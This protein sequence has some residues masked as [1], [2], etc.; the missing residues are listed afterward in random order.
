MPVTTPY[1]PNLPRKPRTGRGQDPNDPQGAAMRLFQSGIQM[2]ENGQAR[3]S[4][5]FGG[6]LAKGSAG[7]NSLTPGV[8]GG[9]FS[10]LGK[11]MN[12][13]YEQNPGFFSRGPQG[14]SRSTVSA[15]MADTSF[16]SQVAE[17]NQSLMGSGGLP[18]DTP[19]AASAAARNLMMTGTGASRPTFPASAST[20]GGRTRADNIAQ[21]KKDGT[22]ETLR[23]QFNDN[24]P[25]QY[26][27]EKGDIL[28]TTTPSERTARRGQYWADQAAANRLLKQASGDLPT[29]TTPSIIYDETGQ[30]VPQMGGAR[31]IEGKY[32]RGFIDPTGLT[33]R[34]PGQ[35]GLIN[36]RPASEV[37]QGLANKPGIAREGDKFQPQTLTAEEN[38]RLEEAA[39][40][41]SKKARR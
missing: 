9:Q 27:D 35:E 2:G 26:M 13:M 37:M 21:A 6:L 25:D 8:R 4:Q 10:S 16:G 17:R 1:A 40:A 22:F 41:A 32:G 34:K 39:K 38:K 31:N 28:S 11:P 15:P 20:G 29:V 24:A 30:E 19:G 18:N 3:P 33:R 14:L 5:D 36:G 7:I 12:S 23:T